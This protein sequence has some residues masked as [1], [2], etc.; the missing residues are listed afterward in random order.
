[1]RLV[2]SADIEAAAPDVFGALTDLGYFER[3]SLRHGV[4]L[5]RL[6]GQGSLRPGAEW[7]IEFPFRGRLREATSRIEELDHPRRMVL[8]GR[9]SGFE[10]RAILSLTA[11]SRQSTRLWA[12]LEVRP[13]SLTARVLLQT[14]KLGRSRLRGRYAARLAAFAALLQHRIGTRP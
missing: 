1:M 2:E 7:Q 8:C 12:D 3:L 9:S 4:S 10:Y 14:L 6:D 5:E 11:L 13:K